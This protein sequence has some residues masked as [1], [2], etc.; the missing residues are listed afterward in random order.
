VRD[1]I[2][3]RPG[4]PD[5]HLTEDS[6][7]EKA[8]EFD[9]NPL[10][11][12]PAV[13]GESDFLGHGV[14]AVDQSVKAEVE[15]YSAAPRVVGLRGFVTS[16]EFDS[17]RRLARNWR[18]Q[19]GEDTTGRHF[20]MAYE[21]ELDISTGKSNFRRPAEGEP[22]R[23]KDLNRVQ[24]FVRKMD[25]LILGPG[26]RNMMGGSL[27]IRRYV[28]GQGH[29]PHVDT[30]QA[31]DATLLMSAMLTMRAPVEGGATEFPK[32]PKGTLKLNWDL[33]ELSVWW[34][35]DSKGASDAKAEHLG[36]KVTKGVKW[37]ATYFIYHNDPASVCNLKHWKNV[38]RSGVGFKGIM[39]WTLPKDHD[40][41]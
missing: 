30:Y 32:A 6:E 2:E 37:T 15:V 29:P 3:E 21:T 36:G 38:F 41:L 5:S 14:T 22:T 25:A 10:E 12:L 11:D 26:R 35:C 40:E 23:Q 19:S 34:S 18:G 20:E 7:E 24:G 39:N 9:E 31:S 1:V 16:D 8:L 28:E 13:D 4:E 17:I 33:G 27:R